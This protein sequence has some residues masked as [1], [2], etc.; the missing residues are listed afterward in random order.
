MTPEEFWCHS[1][2]EIADII[3]GMV[4]RQTQ[5]QKR[6]ID[7]LFVLAEVITRYI[8]P[9]KGVKEPPH[10]WEYYPNL[11]ADEKA[12][13]EAR[14]NDSEFQTYKENRRAYFKRFNEARHK[15]LNIKEGEEVKK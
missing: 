10:P 15:Q 8:T 2:L 11:F 3:D 14:Q 9:A 12:K 5:E 13:Y 1:P 7:Q 4:Y 6:N